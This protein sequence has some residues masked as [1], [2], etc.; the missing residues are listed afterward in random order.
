MQEETGYLIENRKENIAHPF[1]YSSPPDFK[2][3]CRAKKCRYLITFSIASNKRNFILKL[4]KRF[5]L[6]LWEMLYLNQPSAYT[7]TYVL[8]AADSK[9]DLKYLYVLQK[10]WVSLRLLKDFSTQQFLWVYMASIL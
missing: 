4:P 10:G 8:T 2:G 6:P 9:F 5:W 7:R 1:T 3:Y